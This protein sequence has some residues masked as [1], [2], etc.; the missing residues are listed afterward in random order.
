[1][2]SVL[3]LFLIGK[4]VVWQSKATIVEKKYKQPDAKCNYTDTY[5]KILSP[6]SLVKCAKLCTTSDSCTTFMRGPGKACVLL[7]TCDPKCT[8]VDDSS[9]SWKLYYVDGI[10]VT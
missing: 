7:E 9:R 6:V 10:V 5:S 3:L 8:Q 4:A 2:F 1:M